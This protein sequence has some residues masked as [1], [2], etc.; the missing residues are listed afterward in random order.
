M[1]KRRIIVLLAGLLAILMMGCG[2]KNES[3]KLTS[4]NLI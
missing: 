4:Q 1:M 2:S 3:N